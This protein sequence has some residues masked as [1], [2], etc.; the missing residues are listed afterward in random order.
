MLDF[1]GLEGLL[2]AAEREVRRSTRAFLQAEAAPLIRTC[3][4]KGE[5]PRALVPKLGQQGLLGASLP[6]AWGGGGSSAVA[7]GL[8][9]YELERIDSGLR[10]FAS[11]Q[12]SLVM[13][14]I[15]RYG[16]EAQ[17]QA[18]LERLGC[19]KAIGCFALTES[20]GGSDPLGNMTTRVR[21]EGADFVLSGSKTW[22]TN[23]S[24]ADVAVVWAK[25]EAGEIR[26]FL[27]PRD[28]P[29]FSSRD[30]PR[31]LSLRA[32]VTS[33]LFFDDVRVSAEAALPGAVGLKS[34]LA[35]LNQARLGIAWGS[36]GALEAVYTEALAY[37][38]GRLTF[39]APLASRQL[40]QDKLVAMLA[41]HA[42]GTLLAWRLG[43]L[44]DE[45]EL[46]P[47]QVS[48][49]KRDNVRAALNGA[50]SAREILGAAGICL[51][52]DAIRHMLNLETVDTYEGTH[53][54]H[55][56]ILGRDLTGISAF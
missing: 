18:Y 35:C 50:R 8:I 3:W 44:A 45:G 1:I 53:D 55:T 15:G 43:R 54:I 36:M 7:H 26:G 11:V 42:C 39:G 5:F 32:S 10:S 34:V 17:R 22:I 23:G 30:I 24:I 6:P 14:P 2:S 31:K 52:H 20:S 49:G 13:Y 47:A 25:D 27:V 4:E 41:D 56:L 38:Q 33:E 16:S 19:G 12:S 51:D 9:M 21:S 29:G 40:V 28:T 46:R 48:L 37:A